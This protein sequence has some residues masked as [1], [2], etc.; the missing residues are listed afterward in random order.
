MSVEELTNAPHVPGT[1]LYDSSLKRITSAGF[2]YMW[3]E[4]RPETASGV[5][6]TSMENIQYDAAGRLVTV[7]DA[8]KNSWQVMSM[9]PPMSVWRRRN[10][11]RRTPT[12]WRPGNPSSQST[13]TRMLRRSHSG[14]R[15]TSLWARGF[16]LQSSRQ[17]RTN[18]CSISTLTAVHSQWSGS[19]NTEQRTTILF[20]HVPL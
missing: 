14:Q 20:P 1:R 7:S 12:M 19:N 5:G 2:A 17:A 13:R 16:W 6:P 18:T 10:T 11:V 9:A 15:A 8:S 3:P 4:T